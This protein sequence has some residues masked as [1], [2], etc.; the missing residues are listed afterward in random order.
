MHPEY[1]AIPRLCIPRPLPRGSTPGKAGFSGT[2]F[3]RMVV[4]QDRIATL[5]DSLTRTDDV[6]KAIDVV[7]GYVN[8]RSKEA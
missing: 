1:N 4:D 5:A 3:L 6:T 8:G 7:R 2:A